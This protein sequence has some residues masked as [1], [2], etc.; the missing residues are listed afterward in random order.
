[1][2]T[3]TPVTSGN[4]AADAGPSRGS[5]TARSGSR[6]A[7]GLRED[8]LSGELAPGTRAQR[9]RAGARRSA[10]AAGRSARRSGGSR[11]EGLVTITPG[12][13]PSSPSSP[14]EEFVDAYQVREALE[15]LA[16]RLAVPR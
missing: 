7:T 1:M 3:D 5:T 10:S 12:A 11:S 4:D 15:T 14:A 6:C 9:G 8:I 2:T 13:A 16:V